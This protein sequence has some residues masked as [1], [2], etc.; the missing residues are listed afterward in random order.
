MSKALQIIA[1]KYA[2]CPDCSIEFS[3]ELVAK[4]IMEEN[5]VAVMVMSK[6]INFDFLSRNLSKFILFPD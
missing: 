2:K 4:K 3:P 1:N 5:Y 6:P